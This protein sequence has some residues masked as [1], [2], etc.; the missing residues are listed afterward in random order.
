MAEPNYFDQFVPATS[1]R[2]GTFVPAPGA[3]EEAARKAR[4]EQR[5]VEDAARKARQEGRDVVASER[6]LIGDYR[7]EFLG[8]A[9][10]KD[11]KNVANATRQIVTLAQGDNTAM[12]DI[13]L[14]FSY[15]KALDPG[16]VVREGEQASAQNAAGVPEQIRNAYNRLASVLRFASILERSPGVVR[17]L[18]TSSS[19]RTN[20]LSCCGRFSA[21]KSLSRPSIAAVDFVAGTFPPGNDPRPANCW[22]TFCFMWK[23]M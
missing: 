8:D 20:G 11:F 1:S 14:I 13:G 7:K 9:Q 10:V 17:L 12:G 4:D 15:M 5:A 23:F 21:R 16:S 22:I 3:A 2:G 6:G 18:R 19:W